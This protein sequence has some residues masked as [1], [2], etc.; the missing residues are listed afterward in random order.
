MHGG[1]TMP[2][3]K[4]H[5]LYRVPIRDMISRTHTYRYFTSIKSAH[6]ESI[7]Q[8][9]RTGIWDDMEEIEFD[10]TKKGICRLLNEINK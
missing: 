5:T 7:L 10:F 1:K 2:S 8:E 9:K 6:A 3:K 4:T